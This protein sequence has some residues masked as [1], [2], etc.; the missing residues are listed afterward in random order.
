M[1]VQP[2]LADALRFDPREIVALVGGGGKTCLLQWLADDLAARGRRVVATTTTGMYLQQLE[3]WGPV[4]LEPDQARLMG[5]VQACFGPAG[6]VVAAA[7][8]LAPVALGSAALESPVPTSAA[9]ESPVPTSSALSSIVPPADSALSKV[10]GVPTDWPAVLGTAADADV[11]VEADGSKGKSLKAFAEH[12][13]AMPAGVTTIVQVAGVDVIGET[14]VD[15]FVHRPDLVARMTGAAPGAPVTLDVFAACLSGQLTELRGRWPTA[16]LV[17]F[18]NKTDDAAGEELARQAGLRLLAAAAPP[19]L[20]LAGSCRD[21]RFA[22]V[23]ARRRGRC[24]RG[25]LRYPAG[26]AEAVAT[27]LGPPLGRLG[28]GRGDAVAS[29]RNDRCRRL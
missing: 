19:D 8:G 28:G 5:G 10:R 11:V 18:L 22:P 9:L 25:R 20:V 26:T 13:P 27:P 15:E 1:N 2:S 7:T 21:R 24:S 17:T 12:E 29:G 6:G 14:L 4:L 3:R 16:R 23:A